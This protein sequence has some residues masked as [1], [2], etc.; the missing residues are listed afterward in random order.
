MK[1]KWIN[2]CQARADELESGSG[3]I[4]PQITYSDRMTLDLGN[5]TLH[6]RW[7]GEAGN[8][9]GETIAVIP[10]ENVAVL[11]KAILYPEAHLAPYPHP[12]FKEINVPRWI[13]E[14]EEI[15]EGKNAVDLILLSDYEEVI[16]REI[17]QSHLRYIR[18]LWNSIEAAVTEGKSLEEIE[19]RLS[20]EKEFAFVK[21]MPVYKNT[22]DSWI[23]PQHEVHIKHFYRQ[24][25]NQ[26][27]AS[28]NNNRE[29]RQ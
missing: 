20:L 14:L 16:S 10:E 27:A 19:D 9:R 22:S 11:S 24:I 5:L 15:L 7:F 26:K 28:N 13:A 29:V 8:Y 25:M 17:M 12:D 3:L 6:L 2:K 23:R 18:R 21:D 4:L 1:K